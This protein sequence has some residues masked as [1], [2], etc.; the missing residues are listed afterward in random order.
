HCVP[1][2]ARAANALPEPA[3]RLTGTL[4]A[5]LEEAVREHDGIHGTG[6]GA[7]DA[8]ETDA[9][10]LQ[11]RVERAPGE[12]AVGASALQGQV[13]GSC[14]AFAHR[15][16]QPPSRVSVVPVMLPAPG[17]HRKRTAS[18]MSSG[19]VKRRLGCFSA[20][21]ARSASLTGMF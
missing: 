17:P 18:A 10:I 11:Q 19:R 8:F 5:T 16:V 3:Q 6:T 7:A 1:Q 13:D 20:S 4:A 15:A 9:R 12:G 2:H 14:T 21:R